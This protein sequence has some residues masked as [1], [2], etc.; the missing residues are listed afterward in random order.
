MEFD[1]GDMRRAFAHVDTWV[2]DLDDTLYPRSIGI[3]HQM[4]QRVVGFIADHMKIGHA[5]AEAVHIDYYER[6]GATLQGLVELHGVVPKA[7]LDFI[8]DIDLSALTRDDALIAALQA[9]PGRRIVF[10]NASRD[11]AAAALK[12]MGMA[13]LFGSIGS[14]EDSDFVGKPHLS[15]FSGLIDAFGIDAHTSAMF[16]DRVGNLVVPHQLGMKTVLVTEPAVGEAGVV[17][18]PRHVDAVI[19]NLTKFLRDVAPPGGRVRR[20]ASA[21]L[22][23]TFDQ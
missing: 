1:E 16:E 20:A 4:K 11:H 15:A 9:L 12:A 6:Y 23:D 19:V 2:F 3:H 10:T 5:A 18:R 21:P 17:N 7:F 8:H 13:D 14:I 22:Q